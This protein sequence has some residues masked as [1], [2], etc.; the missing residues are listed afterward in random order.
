[1][2]PPP[3]LPVRLEQMQTEVIALARELQELAEPGYEEARTAA[4]WER[5]AHTHGL[6]FTRFLEGTA[7]VITFGDY[8]RAAKKIIV[9]A[10]LDAVGVRERG[11]LRWRHLCGHHA[12]SAHALG[13][14][15]FMARDS[16][17][18][19]VALRIVGCPAEECRP[20]FDPQWPIPFVTGKQ[21]LLS[22]GVFA[23]A[24][25]VLS[26]HLADDAPD[27]IAY[28]ADQARG[29]V[30]LRM[31]PPAKFR[32][33]EFPA[34]E[35]DQSAQLDEIAK[36]A[37]ARA[38]MILHPN[39][40][41][42]T[43]KRGNAGIDLWLET[44]PGSRVSQKDVRT[45]AQAL[46]A[47]LKMPVEP[48]ARYAPLVQDPQLCGRA[49]SI[50][51]AMTAPVR[52]ARLKRLPGATDLGDVSEAAPTLQ[53]FVG[54]TAGVTHERDFRVVDESF[55]YVWPIAFLARMLKAFEDP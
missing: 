49:R 22:E 42:H 19:G 10:D 14:A 7:P 1:M 17:P 20:A 50:L 28:V 31:T 26:T 21:R 47:T 4:V 12:Q 36:T 34:R 43:Y 9:T 44:A 40:V 38:A 5:I 32:A 13:L 30:W 33:P 25:A 35:T 8:G 15:M 11:R 3:L 23:G 27:R 29:G 45:L 52:V 55:A 39:C 16:L 2:S 54:G 18:D 24:A 53:L 51:A 41:A 48:V 6:T 37:A 46:S